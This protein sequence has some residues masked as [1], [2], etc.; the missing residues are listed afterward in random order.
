MKQ[1]TI[2][3]RV[4]PDRAGRP[5][6]AYLTGWQIGGAEGPGWTFDHTAPEVL[7][8]S[9]A[10]GRLW[11]DLLGRDGIQAHMMTTEG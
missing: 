1:I 3:C 4:L 6:V 10:D 11:I 8:G 7:R 9:P 5:R 2:A